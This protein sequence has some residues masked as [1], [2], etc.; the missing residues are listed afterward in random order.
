MSMRTRPFFTALIFGLC[1]ALGAC[2]TPQKQH[3]YS[4]LLVPLPQVKDPSDAYLRAAVK[5]TLKKTGGPVSSSYDFKR[6]DLNGDGRRDALVFLKTPYGYWC[7]IYGCTMLV[8]EAHNDHFTFVNHV[9]PV[10][11][12]IF[13]S[14]DKSNGWQDLILR[15]SGRWDEAK[16]VILSFNG[17]AYPQNPESQPARFRVASKDDIRLFYE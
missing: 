12:P 3:E 2:S 13:I 6:H 16:D 14:Q 7:N 5:E 10:R 4:Q 1:L 15:V 17:H 9:Q 8:F 11:E